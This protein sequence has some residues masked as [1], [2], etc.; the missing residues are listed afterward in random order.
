MKRKKQKVIESCNAPCC[1]YVE[2]ASIKEAKAFVVA[3]IISESSVLTERTV[4]A[5]NN[6]AYKDI[7]ENCNGMIFITDIQENAH[8][9]VFRGH[10][11]IFV[12]AHQ[13]KVMMHARY[14]YPY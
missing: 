4:I 10:T 6:E 1:L 13:I 11:V 7:V 14:I 12:Y 3:S 5:T 8:Y 9:V 2:A